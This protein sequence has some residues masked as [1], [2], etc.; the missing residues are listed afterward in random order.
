MDIEKGRLLGPK[1]EIP[2][3]ATFNIFMKD[4]QKIS[5]KGHKGHLAYSSTSNT[6]PMYEVEKILGFKEI[7]GY[8]AGQPSFWGED[9][10]TVLQIQWANV[11]YVE[12]V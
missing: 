6:H 11:S 4:G 12:V 10:F 7:Q 3:L 8:T 5:I 2:A 1:P 9:K